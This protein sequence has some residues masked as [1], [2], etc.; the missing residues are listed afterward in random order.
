MLQ[1]R[2]GNAFQ[3]QQYSSLEISE[4]TFVS[5]LFEKVKKKKEKEIFHGGLMNAIVSYF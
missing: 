2:G 4:F 1:F 5:H 3:F